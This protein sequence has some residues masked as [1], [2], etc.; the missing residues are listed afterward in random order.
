[1]AFKIKLVRVL[2]SCFRS[3]LHIE[4]LKND[5]LISLPQ[6]GQLLVESYCTLKVIY[7]LSSYSEES[8][9]LVFFHEPANFPY[10]DIYVET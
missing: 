7:K 9:A 10:Q 4:G 6:V 8:V 5:K 1:M 3:Y 2:I